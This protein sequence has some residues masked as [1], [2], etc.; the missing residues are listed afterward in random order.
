MHRRLRCAS[1][2]SVITAHRLPVGVSLLEGLCRNVYQVSLM[3][4]DSSVTK[5]LMVLE[6]LLGAI[7]DFP[8][9][10]PPSFDQELTRR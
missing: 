9:A 8:L 10:R 1:L 6:E 5:T 3:V 2:S 4:Y 7:E